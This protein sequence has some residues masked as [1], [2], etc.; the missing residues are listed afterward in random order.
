[1]YLGQKVR[2]E[3]LFE[4]KKNLHEKSNSLNVIGS[5]KKYFVVRK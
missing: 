2:K 3:F 4:D 5:D 1:V